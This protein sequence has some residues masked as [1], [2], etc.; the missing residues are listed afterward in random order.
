M[1]T[2]TTSDVLK[3]VHNTQFFTLKGFCQVK[4]VL[5]AVKGAREK[6]ERQSYLI[7]N[8]ANSKYVCVCVST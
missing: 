6:R 7:M 5:M 1:T 4:E 8:S 3:R 2:R